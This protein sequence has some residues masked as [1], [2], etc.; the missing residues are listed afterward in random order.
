M[1]ETT[2]TPPTDEDGIEYAPDSDEEHFVTL[3][4]YVVTVVTFGVDV[5]EIVILC[6]FLMS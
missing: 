5:I 1:E 6:F 4:M 2:D 3:D